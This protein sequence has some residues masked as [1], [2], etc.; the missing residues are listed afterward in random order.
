MYDCKS[1]IFTEKDF[2]HN[3]TAEQINK[4]AS[5]ILKHEENWLLKIIKLHIIIIDPIS[6]DM[7]GHEPFNKLLL[8]HT[9][10]TVRC[11]LQFIIR[12]YIDIKVA[13]K[14]L[15]QIINTRIQSLKLIIKSKSNY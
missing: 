11:A 8:K 2:P 12:D 13:F 10:P 14:T 15:I 3:F 1:Q 6:E 4:T 5:M 9:I 7:I